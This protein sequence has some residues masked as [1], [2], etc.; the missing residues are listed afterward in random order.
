[1]SVQKIVAI[2]SEVQAQ[3]LDDILDE[4]GIPHMMRSYHDS[5]LDGLIQ[6]SR[7]WGQLDAP[8]E[9][10]EQILAIVEEMKQTAPLTDDTPPEP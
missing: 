5:A 6:A 4:R 9:Y 3:I 2:Q 10:K 7:G 1:M 8:S